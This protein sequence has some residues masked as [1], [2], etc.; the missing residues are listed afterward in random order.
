MRLTPYNKND[1]DRDTKRHEKGRNQATIEEFM[2]SGLDC[3]K[4]EG[5][6]HKSP[7]VCQNAF[8]DGD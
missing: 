4:V 8:L 1:F 3:V 2:D 5:W 6:T 7:E